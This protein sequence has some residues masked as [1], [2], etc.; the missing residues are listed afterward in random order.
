M[1]KI[2][3]ELLLKWDLRIK[4]VES[5]SYSVREYCLKNGFTERQYYYWY[6]RIRGS[7][8]QAESAPEGFSELTFQ[9]EENALS[10]LSIYFGDK[11]KLVPGKG[12]SETEFMRVVR[13]LRELN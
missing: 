7:N 3:T 1:K 8:N 4:E 9:G 12:F 2:S 11:I 5:N 13:L 6:S 10:G